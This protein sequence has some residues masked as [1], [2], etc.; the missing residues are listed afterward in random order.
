VSEPGL[1]NPWEPWQRIRSSLSAVHRAFYHVLG[2]PGIAPLTAACFTADRAIDVGK[3]ERLVDQGDD[4]RHR[5]LFEVV[6]ELYGSDGACRS[7]SC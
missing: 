4:P 7:V 3:L 2:A 6:S 5:L 1:T